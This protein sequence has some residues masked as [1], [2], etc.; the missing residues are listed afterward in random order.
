MGKQRIL[1]Y[2]KW[3][4]ELYGYLDINRLEVYWGWATPTPTPQN[5]VPSSAFIPYFKEGGNITIPPSLGL[6]IPCDTDTPP[7]FKMPYKRERGCLLW[8]LCEGCFPG[9]QPCFYRL[10][11]FNLL[12]Y[13]TFFSHVWA[14]VCRTEGNF[15]SCSGAIP[16]VFWKGVPLFWNPLMR[17]A[18]VVSTTSELAL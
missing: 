7:W 8:G 14:G 4:A 2:W 12:C 11:T 3:L 17:L 5:Q 18:W 16:L 1:I 6:E 9:K 15:G 10:L 13:M